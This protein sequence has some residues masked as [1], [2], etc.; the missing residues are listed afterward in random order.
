MERVMETYRRRSSSSMM[1]M[2]MTM[3]TMRQ[4]ETLYL[5]GFHDDETTIDDDETTTIDDVEH[6]R[7]VVVTVRDDYRR[8]WAMRDSP[9][10]SSANGAHHQS[11]RRYLA[12]MDKVDR[13]R[14][15]AGWDRERRVGA[16]ETGMG[17]DD[18]RRRRRRRVL[19]AREVGV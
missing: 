17:R 6:G 15:A 8:C 16:R 10:A 18:D 14:R 3:M 4:V 12:S 13:S 2:M 7:V 1:M 11:S 19:P 5:I 9:S